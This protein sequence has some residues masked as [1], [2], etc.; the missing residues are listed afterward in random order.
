MLTAMLA[1]AAALLGV[2]LLAAAVLL[3]SAARER[4]RLRAQLERLEARVEASGWAHYRVGR[5]GAMRWSRNAAEVLAAGGERL[6]ERLDEW[7]LRIDPAHRGGMEQRYRE[8]REGRPGGAR[9]F[10]LRHAGNAELVC[11]EIAD[12][13]QVRPAAWEV[14]PAAWEVAGMVRNVTAA[15]ARDE[16]LKRARPVVSVGRIAATIAHDLANVLTAIHGHSQML[17][18]AGGGGTA[19]ATAGGNAGRIGAAIMAAAD[20]GRQLCHQILF[21]ARPRAARGNVKAGELVEELRVMLSALAR[22]GIEVRT[23]IEHGELAMQCD[24]GR[25]LQALLNLCINALESMKDGGVLS[26]RCF[27]ARNEAPFPGALGIV[28]VGSFACFE[29]CDTGEGIPRELLGRIFEPG[30][31]TKQGDAPRGLGLAIIASVLAEI[32][33]FLDVDSRASSA[34]PGAPHGTTFRI[35]VP[36]PAAAPAATVLQGS[37]L[38]RGEPILIMDLEEE[39][40]VRMEDMIASIG[41]EPNA[42]STGEEAIGSARAGR[43]YQAAVVA[44]DATLADGTPL[45]QALAG[46]I[47]PY[48]IVLV[49][50]SSRGVLPGTMLGLVE[51]FSQSELGTVL[52]RILER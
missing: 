32:G 35:Y 51:P 11:E 16:E 46:H 31:T 52:A 9:E 29:V 48:R 4:T 18:A 14:R 22:P 17:A 23:E 6:P 43:A 50:R 28:H 25:L 27:H 3:R 2:C 21:V 20:R 30:Y 15:K 34:D 47:P 26:L 7:L 33:A 40:L 10:V 24:T 38:G 19:G 5:D 8:L 44:S 37:K 42:F 1:A 41:Y 12:A 45:H 49:S 13:F 36:S 39:R